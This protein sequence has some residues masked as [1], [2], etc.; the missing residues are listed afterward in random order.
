MLHLSAT[1]VELVSESCLRFVSVHIGLSFAAC[2]QECLIIRTELL[3]RIL[4]T[5]TPCVSASVSN[6]FKLCSMVFASTLS[7]SLHGVRIPIF[8]DELALRQSFEMINDHRTNIAHFFCTFTSF[9]AF[10]TLVC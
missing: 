4:G 9:S 2:Q 6:H 8:C 1:E 3:K 7:L 5:S 10:L